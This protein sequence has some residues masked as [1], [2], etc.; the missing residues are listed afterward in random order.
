MKGYYWRDH[1]AVGC[2]AVVLI[3][4]TVAT[5]LGVG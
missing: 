5:V 3:G 4:I 2:L 1:L